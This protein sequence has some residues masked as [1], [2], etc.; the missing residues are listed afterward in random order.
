M[1]GAVTRTSRSPLGR[2][3]TRTRLQERLQTTARVVVVL[4]RGC[5]ATRDAG[6]G[7]AAR[8]ATC[9]CKPLELSNVTGAAYPRDAHDETHRV[10]LDR[11]LDSP[12][13]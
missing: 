6:R 10:Y 12:A 13:K 1:H 2:T 11:H 3:A 7:F 9:C 5:M 8:P 4:G